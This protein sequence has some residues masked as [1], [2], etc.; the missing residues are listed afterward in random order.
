M[1]SGPITSWQIEGEKV[2]AV[3]DFIFL[4]SKSTAECNSRQEIKSSILKSRDITLPT[5]VHSQS[6]DSSR[7]H[8]QMWKLDHKESWAPKNSCFWT[9]GLEKT[10]ENLLQCKETKLVHPKGNRSWIFIG[11][12]DAE[13]EAPILGS[14]DVK[15]WLIGKDPDAGKDW[16]WEEKGTTEDEMV[17]WHHWVN[18]H[19][20]EQ[21]P[22]YSGVQGSLACC[23]PWGHKELDTT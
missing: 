16:R 22:G 4:G 9:V 21:T 3:T 15:N 13:A 23:S 20:F 8:A 6:Y 14:H 11:R 18:G 17:G 7:S 10:F 12:M 1:A 2:E 19:E 5:E